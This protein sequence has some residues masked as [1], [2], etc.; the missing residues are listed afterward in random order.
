M[1]SSC[2]QKYH[3]TGRRVPGPREAIIAQTRPVQIDGD[4]STA[5]IWANGRGVW[6]LVIRRHG[7]QEWVEVAINPNAPPVYEKR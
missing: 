7:S 1:A 4:G 5:A 2:P 6:V 3:V